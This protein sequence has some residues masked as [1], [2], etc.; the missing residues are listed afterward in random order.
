MLTV[1]LVLLSA[2]FATAA[3]TIQVAASGGRDTASCGSEIEPCGTLQYAIDSVATMNETILVLP[4]VHHASNITIPDKNLTITGVTLVTIHG[5]VRSVVDCRRLGWGFQIIA[6]ATLSHLTIMNCIDEKGIGGGIKIQAVATVQRVTVEGCIAANGGG[7][8]VTNGAAPLIRHVLVQ[9]N[10]AK[11]GIIHLA[12]TGGGIHISNGSAPL[13]QHALVTNN[14]AESSGGGVQISG[15]NTRPSF[16]N[17][18]IRQNRAM[19]SGL[20][21]GVA[22]FDSINSTFTRTFIIDNSEGGGV[23]VA[24]S[25]AQPTFTNCTISRNKA[26][27]GGGLIIFNSASPIFTD[28]FFTDNTADAMGGGLYVSGSGIQPSFTNCTISGNQAAKFGG[29]AIVLDSAS[30]AFTLTFITDNI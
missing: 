29:G 2:C 5:I 11:G 6:R 9:N 3:T 14:V 23:Y 24:G 30:P 12:A 20:G 22:I 16:I 17:C 18:T 1:H 10:L 15:A 7:I 8:S 26:Q 28:T 21:G 27:D 13:I 4:G 25:G 19:F